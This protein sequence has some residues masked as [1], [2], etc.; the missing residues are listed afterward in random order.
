MLPQAPDLLSCLSV[1]SLVL[2]ISHD[3]PKEARDLLSVP[4]LYRCHLHSDSRRHGLDCSKLRGPKGKR[5]ISKD[6]NSL[7][8]WCNLFGYS[9]RRRCLAP[10]R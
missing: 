5:R 3:P 6:A 1:S 2:A 4:A 8:A 7:Y 9:L 10:T